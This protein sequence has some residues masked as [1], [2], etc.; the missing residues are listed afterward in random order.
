M[1][2]ILDIAR[3]TFGESGTV[4]WISA[5]RPLMWVPGGDHDVDVVVFFNTPSL[6]AVDTAI[7]QFCRA[8][9]DA[10]SGD[11]IFIF[12]S[13][14]L[15]HLP[16]LLGYQTKPIHLTCYYSKAA[17]LAHDG[18]LITSAIER[19]FTLIWGQRPDFPPE[20]WLRNL[21][22]RQVEIFHLIQLW[23]ETRILEHSWILPDDFKSAEASHKYQYITKIANDLF[24]ISRPIEFQ[25]ASELR[26]SSA[27]V[28]SKLLQQEGLK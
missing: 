22:P 7:G 3:A 1:E 14:R 26:H 27:D 16:R 28:L 17:A 2:A 24:D 13:F 5:R 11:R 19:K 15:H 25:S 4:S 21:A 18:S 6:A 8:C 12:P 10:A 23:I 20:S 9:R